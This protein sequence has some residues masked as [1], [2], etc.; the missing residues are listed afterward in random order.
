MSMS[1]QSRMEPSQQKQLEEMSDAELSAELDRA[2]AELQGVI[3]G[4]EE[5]MQQ[6]AQ[7]APMQPPAETPAAQPTANE[8][9][10]TIPPEDLQQ[11]T[12]K[13]VAMGLVDKATTQLTPELLMVFQ[14]VID[15]IDP[16]LFDLQQPEQLKEFINGELRS[17]RPR[18]RRQ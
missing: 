13:M 3:G 9:L 8:M 5:G 10:S 18:H 17:N 6:E 15:A 4:Q 7:P 14:L 16:G 12:A 11:A 1:Q 2:L